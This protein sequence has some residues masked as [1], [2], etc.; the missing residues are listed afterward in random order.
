MYSLI[1]SSGEEK[2]TAKEVSKS[3]IKNQL[4]HSMYRDCL[5]NRSK[6][7]HTMSLIRSNNHEL[8]F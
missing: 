3:V 7:N 5:L 4:K 1:L 8:L 6:Y 2:K